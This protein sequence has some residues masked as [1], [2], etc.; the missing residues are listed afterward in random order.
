MLFTR[1]PGPIIDNLFDR[2]L[3]NYGI[4]AFC[5]SGKTVVSNPKLSVPPD[6]AG[7]NDCHPDCH[8]D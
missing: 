8:P 7:L 3:G 1:N 6:P 4:S 5:Q 2:Q